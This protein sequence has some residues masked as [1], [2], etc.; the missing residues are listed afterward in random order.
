MN[1]LP[2]VVR[3][4]LFPGDLLWKLLVGLLGLPGLL[5]QFEHQASFLMGERFGVRLSVVTGNYYLKLHG[6]T[7]KGGIDMF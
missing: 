1:E 3:G 4:P 2:E 7:R 6:M 5:R